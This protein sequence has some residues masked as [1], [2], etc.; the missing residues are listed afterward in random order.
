MPAVTAKSRAQLALTATTT[1]PPAEALALVKQTTE[2]VKGG[3]KSL[4]TSGAMNLGAT[5]HV[6]RERDHELGLSITSGKRL[7]ELCTFS[8]SATIRDG[9]TRLRVGGLQ[10][11]KTSQS[12]MFGFIPTGPK[13]I[14]G[15]DPYQ[16]FLNEVAHSLRSKDPA[17]SVSVAIPSGS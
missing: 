3:G 6:E 11:Y 13:S 12:T 10:R 7:V 17:A 2:R 1:L 5:I 14:A 4:L 8:A 9:A 15:Y 16:R